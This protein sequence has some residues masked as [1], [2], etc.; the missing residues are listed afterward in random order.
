[1]TDVKQEVTEYLESFTPVPV[2]DRFHMHTTSSNSLRDAYDNEEDAWIDECFDH[3]D[4][5]FSY[6]F[7]APLS[8]DMRRLFRE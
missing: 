3:E 8:P 1:M 4:G 5:E 2:S 6:E 7:D